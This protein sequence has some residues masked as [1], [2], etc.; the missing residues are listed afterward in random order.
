MLLASALLTPP[1]FAAPPTVKRPLC[2]MPKAQTRDA[3]RAEPCRKPAIPPLIDPTPLF[4]ASTS[5]SPA[6]LSDLS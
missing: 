6:V 3:K 4:L 5:A 1:V 2:Q